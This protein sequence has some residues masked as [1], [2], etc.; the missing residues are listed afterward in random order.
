MDEWIWDLIGDQLLSHLWKHL[1]TNTDE[2]PDK[3]NALKLDLVSAQGRLIA[4]EI[5]MRQVIAWS[6]NTDHDVKEGISNLCQ[7]FRENQ[8]QAAKSFCDRYPEYDSEMAKKLVQEIAKS[9]R[10]FLPIRLSG[11]VSAGIPGSASASI[12]KRDESTAAE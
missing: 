6:Q 10:S 5:G 8:D 3:I 9:L 12:S 7:H 1:A 2:T 11:H 4:L